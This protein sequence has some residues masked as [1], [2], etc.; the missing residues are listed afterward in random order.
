[1]RCPICD[2][3]DK[4]VNVDEHRFSKKGMHIC[5]GC[6]FVSYPEK[7]KTEDEIRKYYE[8]DYRACP[9]VNNAFTGQRKLHIHSAFLTETLDKWVKQG[10]KNP[11]IC[12]VGAAYGLFLN[13]IRGIFPEAELNGTEYAL[14]YRRNA[15]HEYGLKLDLEFDK[16]KKY[17]L[18]SSFKVAEHQMDVDLRLREYAECLK[19]DGFLY[20]SVPLWF[21]RMSNFGADG[22]DLEY[23]YDPNHIN[24]WSREHFEYLLTK[25]GLEVLK[26]DD[27]MY[28]TTYLCKRNDAVMGTKDVPNLAPDVIR[29]MKAIKAAAVK[30]G[31]GDFEGAIK[32]FG[33][34]PNAWINLYETVRAKAH[35]KNEGQLPLDYILTNVLDHAMKACPQSL[36]IMR[37][38]ADVFMRYDRY[39]EAADVLQQALEKR[40]NNASFLMALSHCFREIAMRATDPQ[41]R[42]RMFSESRDC[43]RYL[44]DI[45]LQMKNDA[46]NWIYRD[47][48]ELPT[49]H[50]GVKNENTV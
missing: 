30:S 31:A 47:N 23:Y 33:N 3:T 40:P 20:I 4:W 7:Y 24:A 9:S 48:S 16:T 25:C 29:R 10:F 32:E 12:D 44:R 27:W 11:V 14:A 46:V 42:L 39:A 38:K 13:W 22:F 5:N 19:E 18:I 35:Q 26:V 8:K 1:M 28:D 41:D 36:D 15:W 6:G 43:A 17:D 49:P 37:L 2:S 50:E 45:D 21:H 34:F